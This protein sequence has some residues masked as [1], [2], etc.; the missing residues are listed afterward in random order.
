MG[1]PGLACLADKS[2]EIRRRILALI[3][4]ACEKD[5]ASWQGWRV[6]GGTAMIELPELPEVE[7]NIPEHEEKIRALGYAFGMCAGIVSPAYHGQPPPVSPVYAKGLLKTN[8]PEAFQRTFEV[9]HEPGFDFGKKAAQELE[10]VL[11]AAPAPCQWPICLV[12][13]EQRMMGEEYV[14]EEMLAELDTPIQD[15][16]KA[17][18]CIYQ[19]HLI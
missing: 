10:A 4:Y 11:R 12:F 18:R 17:F 19:K 15:G 2:G 13:A 7:L 16:L 8:D 9:G 6:E 1:F 14:S 5:C 3:H